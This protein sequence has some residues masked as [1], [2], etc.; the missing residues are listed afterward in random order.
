MALGYQVKSVP[1][2]SNLHPVGKEANSLNLY[3]QKKG[4]RLIIHST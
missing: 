3:Y 2:L 1:T 4:P